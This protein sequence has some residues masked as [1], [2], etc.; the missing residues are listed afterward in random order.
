MIAFKIIDAKDIPKAIQYNRWAELFDSIPKGKALEISDEKM[1][2]GAHQS[3]ARRHRQGLYQNLKCFRRTVDG[4][5]KSYILNIDGIEK[6][7]I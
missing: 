7:T 3:L 6:V 5:K 4:I 1:A 2:Y